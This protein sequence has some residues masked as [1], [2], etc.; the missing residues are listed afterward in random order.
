MAYLVPKLKP[1]NGDI[2]FIIDIK[3]LGLT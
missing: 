2:L 1:I 3:T